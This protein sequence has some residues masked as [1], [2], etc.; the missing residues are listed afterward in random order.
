MRLAIRAIHAESRRTYGSPRIQRDLQAQGRRHGR[1]RI[2]RLMRLEGLQAKRSRRYRATTQSPPTG[3]AA[4]NT[5]A[6][7][8]SVRERDRVWAGDVT[9]CWTSEGWLYVAVLLDLA[10]R[11]LVGWATSGTLDQELTRTALWRGLAQR[12]PGPGLLHHSD[13]GT[14]YTGVDYQQALAAAGITISMSRRGDC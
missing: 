1:K 9:A 3:P 12:R 10:S 11:R 2:A 4:P 14:H 6:R 7:C 8:F 13:R 5:L